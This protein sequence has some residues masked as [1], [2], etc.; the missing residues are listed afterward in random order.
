MHFQQ[1]QTPNTKSQSSKVGPSPYVPGR[2]ERA[3]SIEA[4]PTLR[5]SLGAVPEGYASRKKHLSSFV[6]RPFCLYARLQSLD[7]RLPN[8]GWNG[9][10][11]SHS[12]YS[13]S[14]EYLQHR[15]LKGRYIV[16]DGYLF[17][18]GFQI[19]F[20]CQ[21]LTPNSEATHQTAGG[22]YHTHAIPKL[23]DVAC[24]LARLGPGSELKGG[25][26]LCRAVEVFLAASLSPFHVYRRWVLGGLRQG[27]KRIRNMYLYP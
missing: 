4:D 24:T 2:P 10:M 7:L 6:R 25:T 1:R 14:K 12:R 18:D 26:P 13:W 20:N 22:T 27:T 5:S 16:A 17:F 3:R 15:L 9:M 8:P 11:K 23:P 19:T 21:I